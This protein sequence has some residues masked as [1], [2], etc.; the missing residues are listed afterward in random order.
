M[1][2]ACRE[3]YRS[4]I[5]VERKWCCRTVLNCR[6]LLH[7]RAY[8]FASAAF[9]LLILCLTSPADSLLKQTLTGASETVYHCV[10]PK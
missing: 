6:P 1:T 8:A 2:L 7:H 10:S 3:Q 4:A 9:E 5:S